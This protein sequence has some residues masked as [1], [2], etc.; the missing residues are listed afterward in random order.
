MLIQ[1]LTHTPLYVWAILAFLLQRGLAALREREIA[2]RKLF[3]LPL[4]M[5]ALSLQDIAAKFG[6]DGIALAAWACGAAATAAAVWKG[7]AGRIGAGALPG[8]VRVR[9]SRLP[10]AMMMAVFF[11]KYLTSVACAVLPQLRHDVAFT[12]AVCVLLGACSGWF[13]GR[14]ARDAQSCLALQA[15]CAAAATPVL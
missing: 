7:S 12:A 2:T 4:A 1:I 14:M 11:T 9:G 13:L 15:G 10:L 8:T 6:L 3:I 5:L